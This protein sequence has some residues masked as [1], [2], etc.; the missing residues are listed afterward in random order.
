MLKSHMDAIE[1]TL[2][3]QSKIPAGAGHSLHKGTPREEFIKEF[4]ESHLPASIAIGS[5]EIIDHS[6]KP[7]GMRNQFDIVLYNRSYPKL[8]FGGG[9][10]GF[11]IESVVA[12]I[13]V[14]S[15]LTESDLEQGIKAA[16]NAKQLDPSFT[17]SFIAGHVPPKVLNYVVAYDG[18][19]SMSTVY[20]W[21]PKIHSK[22][23]ITV[24]NLPVALD[25]RIKVPSPSVDG[26]FVLKKGFLY[27]D[28]VPFGF[29]DDSDRASNPGMKWLY[30][31][32]VDGNLL[33]IFML[34][35][36]STQNSTARWLNPEPYLKG[37]GIRTVNIG[38]K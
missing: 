26:V 14:K 35:Q 17:T 38:S 16:V 25:D 10:S 7:G 19:A 33:L 2:V 31:D 23:G 13:E 8:D 36:V 4:L 1:D 15:T 37:V 3:A 12:T 34:L 29:A 21:V 5:G 6:S 22:M 30:A 18:P 28:N 20:G 24:P 32:S 9:L 27:F 11:L